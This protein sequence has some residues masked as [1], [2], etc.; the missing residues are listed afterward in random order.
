M[1]N[2]LN[3]KKIIILFVL[4]IILMTIIFIILKNNS[5]EKEYIKDDLTE[6]QIENKIKKYGQSIEKIIKNTYEKDKI[7][8]SYDEVIKTLNNDEDI[9]CSIHEV[10]EDRN[11]YLDECSYK[12]KKTKYSYGKKQEIDIVNDENKVIIYAN[13][14][15]KDV[16]LEKPIDIDNYKKYVVDVGFKYQNLIFFG[17][18]KYFICNDENYNTYMFD[19]TNS[20]KAFNEINYDSILVFKNNDEFDT[21]YVALS[22]N[23]TW[24][25]YNTKTLEKINNSNY[26]YMFTNINS[27]SNGIDY[28]IDTI[29]N[30]IMVSKNNKKGLVNYKTGKEIISINYSKIVKG[31]NYLYVENDSNQYIFDFLG[32]KVLDNK[33]DSIYGITK[34]DYVIVSKDNNLLLV[35]TTGKTIYNF[36]EL[37]GTLNIINIL[38]YD[39]SL[40]VQFK[41]EVVANEYDC[42]EYSYNLTTGIGD[43]I[44]SYCAFVD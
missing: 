17:N 29:N 27:N 6:K 44:E 20:K 43:I 23:K 7:I 8:L 21:N 14:D 26:D 31:N 18:T 16:T 28:Y 41:K 35:N 42:I 11:I 32:N 39:G 24:S 1:N 22:V 19:Y 5:K 36:G 12:G 37:V 38:E 34:G 30:S 33:Y 3:K 2:K 40:M 10:Y 13:K 15:T 25:I 4:I 9:I